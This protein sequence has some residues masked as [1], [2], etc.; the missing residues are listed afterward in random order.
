MSVN[1]V[2]ALAEYE[3]AKVRISRRTLLFVSNETAQ[4][5]YDSSWLSWNI[6]THIIII[7][8]GEQGHIANQISQINPGIFGIRFS[9]QTI[10]T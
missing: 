2:Y 6:V 4:E 1:Q 7:L 9:F 3:T 8:F 5:K 10:F